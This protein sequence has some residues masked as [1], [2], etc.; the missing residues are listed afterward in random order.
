MSNF[1]LILK[2]VNITLHLENWKQFLTLLFYSANFFVTEEVFS[3]Y[4]GRL[5]P[6]EV[7]LL[8]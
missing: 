4:V 8:R 3:F 7:T 2:T 6:R 5:K 1:L